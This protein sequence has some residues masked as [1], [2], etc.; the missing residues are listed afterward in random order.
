MAGKASWYELEHVMDRDQVLK[1]NDL[2]DALEEAEEDA[3]AKAAAEA[4]R[5]R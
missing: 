5:G 1:A 2:L 4:K 3:R